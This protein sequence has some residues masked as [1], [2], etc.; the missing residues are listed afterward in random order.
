MDSSLKCPL[1]VVTRSAPC[2][3]DRAGSSLTMGLVARPGCQW[4]RVTDYR[5]PPDP[6]S[7]CQL[8]AKPGL[9]PSAGHCSMPSGARP[10]GWCHLYLQ[11]HTALPGAGTH[12][13]TAPVPSKSLNFQAKEKVPC[14]L[15]ERAHSTRCARKSVSPAPRFAFR[16]QPGG[17]GGSEMPRERPGVGDGPA[18]GSLHHDQ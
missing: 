4:T 1:C 9:R 6:H 15:P 12:S 7:A 14:T 13:T 11:T 16:L 10:R 8:L 2:L 5:G 3:S 18:H 17:L